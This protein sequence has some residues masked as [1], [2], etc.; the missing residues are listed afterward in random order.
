M[1][2]IGDCHTSEGGIGSEGVRVEW[3]DRERIEECGQNITLAHSLGRRNNGEP[4]VSIAI[5]QI[6]GGVVSEVNQGER[7]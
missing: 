6:G 3:L 7:G 5:E 2:V 4:I 1:K